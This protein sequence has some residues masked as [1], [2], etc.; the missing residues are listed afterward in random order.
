MKFIRFYLDSFMQD[1]TVFGSLPL[2]LLLAVLAFFSDHALSATMLVMLGV[3][4]ALNVPLK[5]LCF[6]NRPARMR[7]TKLW[8]K[9]E[10]SSFPSVHAERAL[11]LSLLLGSRAQNTYVSAVLVAAAALVCFSRI[12]LKKHYWSDVIAGAALGVA[13]FVVSGQVMNYL[14]L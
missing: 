6:R 13:M 5:L 2:Y 14:G 3:M 8:Q 7:Y 4:Y 10:A 12:Y 9:I 1:I 11:F